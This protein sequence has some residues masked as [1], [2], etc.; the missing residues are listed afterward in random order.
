MDWQ[1]STVL[2]GRLR[3]LLQHVSRLYCLNHSR[4]SSYSGDTMPSQSL[5]AAGCDSTLLIH[6]ATLEDTQ[7]EMALAKAHSTFGQAIDV[8]S[9]LAS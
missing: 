5:I 3:T 1:C 7:V 8:G 4:W 6:E 2:V 9:R